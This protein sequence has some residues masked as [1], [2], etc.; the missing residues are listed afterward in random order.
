M[1]DE[2]I[3]QTEHPTGEIEPPIRYTVAPSIASQITLKTSPGAACILYREGEPDPSHHLKLYADQDGMVRF[4][5]H[6]SGESE[7]LV[8]VIVEYEVG[9]KI[10]RHPLELRAS[11][12]PTLEIPAPA[13]Q[14]PR[15]RREGASVRPALSE[16]EA[17]RLPDEELLKGGYPPRPDPDAAPEAF[18]AWR[19]VVSVPVTMVEPQTVSRPD[20]G[21][22]YARKLPAREVRK[23]EEAGPTEEAGTTQESTNNWSGFELNGA[24]GTYDWVSGMWNVPSVTGESNTHT[25]SLLWVGLDGDGITDLVQAGT[26]QENIDMNLGWIQFSFSSYYAWTEFLPQQ[27]TL[28]QIANFPIH[29]GDEI[30]VEVFIGNAGGGP[31]LTGFFGQFWIENLTTSQSTIVYTP[32]GGTTVVGSEAEWI[33]ERTELIA[34]NGTTSFPD[35]ADYGSAT[36]F[37]AWARRSNSPRHQGYVSYQGDTNV[38]ITMVNGSD[39]LSTVAPIDAVSMR[40]SWQ[41]FH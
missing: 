25:Y 28:Q 22:G 30:F 27:P 16:E 5:V 39:T 19:K 20:I 35:L 40:F 26:G 36:M 13:L 11:S 37:N 17:L 14:G 38:Q 2:G 6:P 3:H 15:A 18:R 31:D 4:H 41:A 1:A 29:P 8:R 33:M 23:T 21:H 12:Q 34:A 9:G 10:T 24:A 7:D 32:R